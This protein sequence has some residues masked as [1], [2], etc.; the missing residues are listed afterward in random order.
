MLSAL[1]SAQRDGNRPAE[2][3]RNSAIPRSTAARFT[4]RCGRV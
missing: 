4:A 1:A 2:A 3:L